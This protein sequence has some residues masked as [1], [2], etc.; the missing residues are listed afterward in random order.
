MI[1]IWMLYCT[2]VSLLLGLAALALEHGLRVRDWPVRWA[3]LVS[4]AA[5]LILPLV[6]WLAPRGEGARPVH[7]ASS[8]TVSTAVEIFPMRS[9]FALEDSPFLMLEQLNGL[10]LALWAVGVLVVL[11][12]SMILL[13]RMHRSRRN[14]RTAWVAGV[15]VLVSRRTGPA[16][17][18]FFHPQIVL[19]EWVLASDEGTQRVVVEH[20]SEH[21]RAGDPYLLLVTIAAV[22]AMPW[23]VALWWQV[24]R[25]RLAIEVDCDARVL[26]KQPDVRRYGMLLLEVG[27]LAAGGHPV[28][29][30]F[31][32]PRS[33][34]E[35]RIRIMTQCKPRLPVA[36]TIASVAVSGLMVVAACEA[37]RPASPTDVADVQQSS[38]V[39]KIAAAPP[40]SADDTALPGIT[41]Q[42]RR[43][44][45]GLLQREYP[46]LLR[47]AGVEGMVVLDFVVDEQGS[48]RNIQVVRATHQAFGD[49]AVRVLREV[50]F[51]PARVGTRAVARRLQLPIAFK[52]G[53][54]TPANAG[55]KP[56]GPTSM[57]STMGDTIPPHIT[58]EFRRQVGRMLE[59]EYPP[60]LRDAGVEGQAV[61]DFVV[62]EQGIPRDVKVERAT[63]EGFG[64]AG[65][66]VIRQARFNPARVGTRAVSFRLQIPIGFKLSTRRSV[67]SR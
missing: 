31:S 67:E 17:V 11:V 60:L 29:A 64:Q 43:E 13:D 4:L 30:A 10:L 57:R 15:P 58:D 6:G 14:W 28:L 8:Q 44:I 2:A 63:H 61:I 46:P 18:G 16:V 38:T 25:L 41:N 9:S 32:E 24:R 42:S 56:R 36:R 45:A 5:S 39:R 49:A 40:I 47:D 59:R 54:P 62:D 20:E 35:R 53:S 7:S 3:W 21:I 33:F 22:L 34:L 50:R 26:R 51:S 37:P 66:A 19:P 48:P 1:A 27:Q 55:V 65:V 23:N 52:L 12:G